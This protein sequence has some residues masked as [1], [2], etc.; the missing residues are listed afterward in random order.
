M[1]TQIKSKLKDHLD[2]PDEVE[3]IIKGN[4]YNE[5]MCYTNFS[6][7]RMTNDNYSIFL[8]LIGNENKSAIK[9][10]IDNMCCITTIEHDDYQWSLIHYLSQYQGDIK[11]INYFFE[12][13][14]FD[15]EANTS[16]G[17]KP[18]HIA[19]DSGTLE[20]IMLLVK[21]RAN[22]EAETISKQKPIH[23]ICQRG[24]HDNTLILAIIKF[25]VGSGVNLESKDNLGCT[26]LHYACKYQSI[27]IIDFLINSGVDLEARDNS[28]WK[29]I[30][31]VCCNRSIKTIQYMIRQNIIFDALMIDFIMK[32]WKL[33]IENKEEILHSINV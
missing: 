12:K 18:I 3:N 19:C 33:S 17:C 11:L 6:L 23:Y 30:H 25:L 15:L 5:L 24:S 32:N 10:V 8:S 29:P 7:C 20:M 16:D 21:N 31:F 14:C 27:E 2:F 13:Y 1:D 4:K 22:I 9:Y 28:G 26:P